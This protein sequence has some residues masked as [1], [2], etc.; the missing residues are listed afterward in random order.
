VPPQQ[1]VVR[2]ASSSHRVEVI[3]ENR[4]DVVLDGEATLTRRDDQA[5]NGGTIDIEEVTSRII[6]RVPTGTKVVV[7]TSSGRVDISG[8]VG[9]VSVTAESARVSIESADHVDVRSASGKVTVEHA[10]G[11]CRI[12]ANSGAVLVSSCENADISTDSGRIELGGVRG[13][14]KAHCISGRIEVSMLE[15]HDVDAETVNGRIKVEL[16]SGTHVHHTK[17]P[18]DSAP[19]GTD[20]VVLTRSVNGKVKVTTR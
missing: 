18:A 4:T 10:R 3:A 7:G 17:D 11:N 9:P 20:C 2:I 15:A 13:Q 8:E 1:H 5:P 16:P 19:A 14:V 12:R 6:V